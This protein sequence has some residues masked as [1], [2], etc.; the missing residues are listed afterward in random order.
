MGTG[1]VKEHRERAPK[2]IKIGVVTAST[3]RYEALQRGDKVVDDSGDAVTEVLDRKG[4]SVLRYGVV[5]D[6]V[7]Q[8]RE[9]VLKGIGEGCDVFI[10]IGGTGVARKDVTVEALRPLF[11]KELPGFGE[12]LRIESFRRI[13]AAAMLSRATAGI[14]MG[15]VVLAFPGSP[16]GARLAAELI[17]EE[18]PHIVGLLRAS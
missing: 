5:D 10:V 7:K 12:V 11:E 17:S 8:I 14:V 3:S 9:A 6:D 4:H 16:D 18:L 1:A 2:T 13:G 15:C